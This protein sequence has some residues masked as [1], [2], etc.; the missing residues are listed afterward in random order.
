MIFILF[1]AKISIVGGAGAVGSYFSTKLTSCDNEVS[2]IGKAEKNLKYIKKHGLKVKTSEGLIHL[3][4]QRFCYVGNL[5]DA[6]LPYQDIV[7][8]SLKQPDVTLKVA[9]QLKRLSNK[10]T[11]FI[12][13]GNGLPFYFLKDLR[14]TK[15]H[16]DCID[17]DGKIERL[18]QDNII[19]GMQPF[20]A[21]KKTFTGETEITRPF[22]KISVII[23]SSQNSKALQKIYEVFE[24]ATIPIKTE[25]FHK[26]TLEKLQFALAINTL[27]AI[28]EKTTGEVFEDPNAQS[29]IKY[30]INI[31][32]EISDKI[33]AGHLRDY[34]TF[35]VL[36]ITKGH[37]SSMYNDLKQNRSIEKAAILDATLELCELLNLKNL[38]PLKRLQA[39]LAAKI[40]G[41]NFN[42]EDF[43]HLCEASHSNSA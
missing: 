21:A 30:T 7:I 4:P 43:F 19:F 6:Q 15:K 9:K 23:G 13:I 11:I 17:S 28:M 27:S 10:E 16:L 22:D 25:N 31:L 41:E 3:K 14:L 29:F 33:N 8:V 5:L 39:I 12:F 42:L 2:I 20:I 37:Y 26:M 24:K 36:P 32:Q 40:N 1:A 35:K 38:A 34:Q 18:F